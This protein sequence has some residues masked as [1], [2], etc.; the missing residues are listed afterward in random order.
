M[1]V[2]VT[3]HRGYLGAAFC[4]RYG[5][6][7]QLNGYDLKDGDDLH[8]V[9]RLVEKMAGCQQVVH[10]AAIPRPVEGEPLERFFK[11]N[12]SATLG[13]LRAAEKSGISRV[14]YASS[15]TIYGIEHGIPFATPITEA[16]PFVSQY[17][18]AD[19]LSCNEESLSYHVSKV[20][21]EQLVAWFGLNRKLQTLALRFGPINKQFLG[22]SVSIRNATHAIDCALR[23]TEEYWYEAFSIVDDLQ[24]IDLTRAKE[25][26]NYSPD[27]VSYQG[28]QI[29]S[30]LDDRAT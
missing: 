10:L 3:G 4:E 6:S 26:L 9:D 13:L 11:E 19:R 12:V 23:S 29:H 30:T 28:D 1:K 14:I 7:Y 16:Q 21:A 24:H 17:L 5:N 18:S 25:R 22:T 2:L 15:T 20:M 8:D 27:P